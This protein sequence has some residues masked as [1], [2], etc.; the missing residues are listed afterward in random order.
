MDSTLIDPVNEGSLLLLS[1]GKTLAFSNAY[2]TQ[3]R[4]NLSIH[5][6]KNKG[7]TWYK[8][9]LVDSTQ[10]TAKIRSYSAYSDLV[11]VTKNSVGIL[12][13]RNGYSEIVFK[14]IKWVK[15]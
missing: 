11:N 13:E 5:L 14:E 12:Y 4:N 3:N 1:D 9:I 8:R 10:N 15:N 2:D 6:S 7:E